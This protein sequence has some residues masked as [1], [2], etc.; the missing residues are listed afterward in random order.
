MYCKLIQESKYLDSEQAKTH[1][2]VGYVIQL[3]QRVEAGHFILGFKHSP[4]VEIH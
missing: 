4:P 3:R 1:P 2:G